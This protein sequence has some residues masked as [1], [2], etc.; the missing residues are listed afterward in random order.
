MIRALSIATTGMLAQQ[1]NIEVIS[2]NISNINTTSYKEN[3]AEFQDLMYQ[4]NSRI[5][6]QTHNESGKIPAG[7][8]VGLGVGVG[9]I[10]R[11]HSQGDMI[12]TQNSYDVAIVGKGYFI[13]NLPNGK[14]AY[15][16]AGKLHVNNE[17]LL[18]NAQGYTISPEIEIPS[19]AV[20]VNINK[21]G[22]VTAMNS[23]QELLELGTI[24]IAIFPNDG[25]L[26]SDGANSYSQTLSSGEA[27][28]LNAGEDSAG[29][30]EQGYL[31]RSNVDPVKE[32]TQMITAQRAYELTAKVIKVSDEMLQTNNKDT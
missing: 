24:D 19:D 10:Y 25:G 14:L 6:T 28:I 27:F 4:N 31:E 13:L 11:K 20:E 18:V 2:N 22:T 15:T 9:S 29:V 17:G 23:E 1:L 32:I 8:Q 12:N 7:V 16:R 21:S 5:G 26:K 30:I 3:R